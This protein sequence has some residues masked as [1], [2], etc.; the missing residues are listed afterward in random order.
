MRAMVRL[1]GRLKIVVGTVCR[2]CV[3]I[4]AI[5]KAL[6]LAYDTQFCHNFQRQ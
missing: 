1:L 2:D 4:M 3:G 5:K 6:R